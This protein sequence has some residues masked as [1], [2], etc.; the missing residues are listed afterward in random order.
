VEVDQ[1]I[2][3]TQALEDAQKRVIDAIDITP[4]EHLEFHVEQEQ[5]AA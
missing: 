1:R 5:K 4:K 2:S 3:I